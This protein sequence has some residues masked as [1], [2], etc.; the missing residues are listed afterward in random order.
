MRPE[1]VVTPYDDLTY[2]IIKV[3]MAVH[4]ELGPGFTESVYHRAMMVGLGQDHVQTQEE[5]PIEVIFKG[6]IVGMYKLDIVAEALVVLELKAVEKL[7]PIHYQQ[8]IAYLTAS[9]LPVGLLINFGAEKLEYKRVFPP[10]AVQANVAYQ[11][12][13]PLAR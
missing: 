12:R 7:S 10:K 3:A 4:N 9:G 11:S 1:K 13:R 5:F 6:Q 2:K 8:I